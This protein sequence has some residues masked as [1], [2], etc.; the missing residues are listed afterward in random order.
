M[1]APRLRPVREIPLGLGHGQPETQQPNSRQYA[2]AKRREI[3]PLMDPIC[4][5]P[6]GTVPGRLS[7]RVA[8]PQ[9]SDGQIS[10][11]RTGG[12][13]EPAGLR[14]PKQPLHDDCRVFAPRCSPWANSSSAL[15]IISA[16]VERSIGIAL[17]GSAGGDEFASVR[18]L[19]RDAGAPVL[20][21]G[22]GERL[23]DLR[24]INAPAQRR[25]SVAGRFIEGLKTNAP[26]RQRQG[27]AML[28]R[29]LG[30]VF[31]GRRRPVADFERRAIG[32]D[33]DR[34]RRDMPPSR[35]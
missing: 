19:Q 9:R 8:V 24:K 3:A 15:A 27:H 32:H 11:C 20:G 25:Q 33:I 31:V 21:I 22:G 14:Q 12:R 18:Q 2:M 4:I 17:A 1:N 16:A 5:R 34:L 6:C 7:R 23:L 26:V 13:I 35:P 30:G 29:E 28:Q 10:V